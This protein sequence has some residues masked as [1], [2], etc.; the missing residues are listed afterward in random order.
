MSVIQ[1]QS[2]VAFRRTE[3]S[4][5]LSHFLP[6]EMPRTCALLLQSDAA[7]TAFWGPD[8]LLIA[9]LPPSHRLCHIKLIMKA[10]FLVPMSDPNNKIWIANHSSEF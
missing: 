6:D 10:S 7:V 4:G 1:A 5:L 2:N 8:N 9:I 3:I